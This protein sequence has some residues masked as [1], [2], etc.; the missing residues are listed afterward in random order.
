M[1][2]ALA[3]W[4]LQLLCL[5]VEVRDGSSCSGKQCDILGKYVIR[6]KLS[7]ELKT[8]LLAAFCSK[9]HCP[10]A[11][12]P[13]RK[14]PTLVNAAGKPCWPSAGQSLLVSC[15]WAGEKIMG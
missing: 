3:P 2:V 13:K 7:G 4:A 9:P 1:G 10:E 11:W 15:Q 6:S 12:N 5:M 14:L 8:C